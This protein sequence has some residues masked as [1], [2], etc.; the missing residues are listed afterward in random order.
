MHFYHNK[1]LGKI[2][3]NTHKCIYIQLKRVCTYSETYINYT[4]AI[5]IRIHGEQAKNTKAQGLSFKQRVASFFLSFPG[6]ANIHQHSQT[7]VL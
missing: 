4:R 7:T 6:E 1:K 3:T 5:S 2:P